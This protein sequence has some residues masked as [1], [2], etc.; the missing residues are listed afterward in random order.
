MT[1]R[2]LEADQTWRRQTVPSCRP[3]V[4][5][6]YLTIGQDLFSINDY[7]MSQYNYTLHHFDAAVNTT[8]HDA[9]MPLSR[10]VPS[11]FMIYTDL[12]TLNGLQEPTDY[13]SGVEYADGALGLFPNQIMDDKDTTER[14]DAALQIGLWL[15]GTSGCSSIY[16]GKMDDKIELLIEYIEHTTASKVFLRVGY[17]FDNPG[18][19]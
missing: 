18:E 5:T 2:T 12:Q 14:S 3:P 11:A 19:G 4:N 9:P 8:P 15:N 16:T 17:E 1:S 6:T 10:L 13:G 7:V